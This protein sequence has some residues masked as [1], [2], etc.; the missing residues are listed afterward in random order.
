[1]S[2]TPSPCNVWWAPITVRRREGERRG[3]E[4]GRGKRRAGE[5]EMGGRERK[6]VGGCEKE[7]VATNVYPLSYLRS[8]ESGA[9]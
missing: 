8:Q 1:M 4:G 5:G 6:R 9:T 2:L 7:E 3:G